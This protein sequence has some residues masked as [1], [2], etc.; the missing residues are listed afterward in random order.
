MRGFTVLDG[1]HRQAPADYVLTERY[2]Q[3]P[4]SLKLANLT[5]LQIGEAPEDPMREIIISKVS[6]VEKKIIDKLVK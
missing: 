1:N 3:K 2:H 6:S 5:T 4:G